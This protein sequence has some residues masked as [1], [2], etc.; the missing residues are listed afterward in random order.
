MEA[1]VKER[2]DWVYKVKNKNN[3]IPEEIKPFYD[4][5]ANELTPEEEEAKRLA[6]LEAKSKKKKKTEKK[7]KKKKGKGDD[8]EDEAPT[9]NVK[10]GNSEIIQKFDEQYGDYNHVWASRDETSNFD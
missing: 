9:S 5:F 10:I 6:D 4:R 7:D 8:D 3:K 1:M 2:R